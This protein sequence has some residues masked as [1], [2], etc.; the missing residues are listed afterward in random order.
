MA[1]KFCGFIYDDHSAFIELNNLTMAL[2]VRMLKKGGS[3]A[4]KTFNGADEGELFVRGLVLI[5]MYRQHI[6][7]FLRC[8]RDRNLSHQELNLVNYILWVLVLGRIR[9]MLLLL[10]R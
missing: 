7:G 4:L 8:L 2:S 1:P 6:L 5:L 9:I 3:V 10:I